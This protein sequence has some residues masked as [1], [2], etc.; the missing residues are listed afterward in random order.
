MFDKALSD[1]MSGLDAAPAAPPAPNTSAINA[2]V[3]FGAN[4][5]RAREALGL[6]RDQVAAHLILAA[7]HIAEIEAGFKGKVEVDLDL[8]VLMTR[9]L[10]ISY[11]DLLDGIG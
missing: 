2:A 8:I 11:A 5:K 9:Q 6:S 1:Q 3:I 10:H 4:F 7:D